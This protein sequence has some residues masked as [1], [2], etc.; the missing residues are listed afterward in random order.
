VRRAAVLVIAC[1][2][3]HAEP[4]AG[5]NKRVEALFDTATKHYELREYAE[6]IAVFKEAYSLMPEPTFLYD[7][8][9]AYRQLRAC[10]DARGFYQNYLRNLPTAENRAKV[11]QF[12]ADMDDCVRQEERERR[13]DRKLLALSMPAAAAEPQP[14]YRMLRLAG[15]VTAGAGLAALGGGVYF[16]L[17]AAHQAS[18][19]ERACTPR[20]E[21]SDVVGIDRHGRASE[22]DA[23]IMYSIGGSLVA[24]GAAM[25]VWATL[26]AG[27]EISVEPTRGGASVTARLRF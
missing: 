12:I 19:L 11:E 16:S 24:G 3:A 8:A 10:S 18:A 2:S 15:I 26:H 9:Q 7:I 17:D 20:C 22:R 4:D 27:P 21:G 14:R 5:V 1:S 25:F 13:A 6:A 23:I